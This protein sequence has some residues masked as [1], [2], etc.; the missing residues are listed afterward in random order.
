MPDPLEFITAAIDGVHANAREVRWVRVNPDIEAGS[1]WIG[2]ILEGKPGE[3]A[4]FARDRE[5]VISSVDWFRLRGGPHPFAADF[6]GAVFDQEAIETLFGYEVI[7][8]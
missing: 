5:I 7:Y 2:G 4:T 1:A 3:P 6:R 8:A